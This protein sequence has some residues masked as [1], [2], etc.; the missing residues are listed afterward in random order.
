[1]WSWME[2]TYNKMR[3]RRKIKKM[4]REKNTIVREE[5]GIQE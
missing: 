5:E 3:R 2:K 1:M 4:R